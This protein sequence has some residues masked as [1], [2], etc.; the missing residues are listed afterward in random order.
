MP[1]PPAGGRDVVGRCTLACALFGVAALA[2]AST[3]ALYPGHTPAGAMPPLGGEGSFCPP[4]DRG[5][6]ARP[7]P[8][9]DDWRASRLA[10]LLEEYRARTAPFTSAGASAN[11]STAPPR[12]LIYQCT[13]HGSCG[14][15]GDRMAGIIAAFVLALA[16]DRSFVLRSTM[17]APMELLY[18]PNGHDWR[19]DT[20]QRSPAWASMA[21]RQRFRDW[22]WH[23][24]PEL[25]SGN[26][27]ALL[28]EDAEAFTL[29]ERSWIPVLANEAMRRKL[30]AHSLLPEN[31]TST[32]AD[33][34]APLTYADVATAVLGFLFS[35]TPALHAAVSSLVS[36]SGLPASVWAPRGQ[37]RGRAAAHTVGLHFRFGT[38]V[39]RPSHGAATRRKTSPPAWRARCD[40]RSSYMAVT[41]VAPAVGLATASSVIA[42]VR[43]PTDFH[44]APHMLQPHHHPH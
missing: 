16:T 5:A 29:S 17:P 15:L 18:E 33:V 13:Q 44:L 40:G 8:L 42:V 27:D 6:T 30:G 26:L 36:T 3:A 32:A 12:L 23:Y 34:G 10:R 1:V 9:F 11:S 28:S 2:V 31:T 43:P 4:R 37:R 25:G 20:L 24:Y 39:L 38:G 22:R 7:P 14:G 21:A 41:R 19:W 35:P